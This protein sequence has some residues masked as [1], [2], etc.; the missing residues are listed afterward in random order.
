LRVIVAWTQI[1]ES[2]RFY[3]QR[4]ENISS[5]SDVVIRFAES[6]FVCQLL[7]VERR[8]GLEVVMNIRTRFVGLFRCI[9]DFPL[10]E[11]EAPSLLKLSI[12]LLEYIF[13]SVVWCW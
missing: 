3:V 11:A 13:Q 8:E 10:R 7:L 12:F 2:N 6:A 9:K 1:L 4:I 5:F